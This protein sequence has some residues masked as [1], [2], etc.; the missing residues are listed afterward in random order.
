[1][2]NCIFCKI[3]AGT[4][5]ARIIHQDD[6]V[7]AFHDLNPQ[8]PTHALIIP[9]RHITSLNHATEADESLLG[10]LFSVARQV[11]ENQGIAQSGYRL[12]VNTGSNAGQSVFHIHMHVL[13]GRA[14]HWP[15]G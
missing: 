8:A 9:N 6:L 11:A 12:V 14:M 7:T 5:P 15:P 10:R 3:A 13:G 4:L 1:M 2:E